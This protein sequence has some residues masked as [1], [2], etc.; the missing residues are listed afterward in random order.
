MGARKNRPDKFRGRGTGSA[1]VKA[2]TLIITRLVRLL[3]EEEQKHPC[4]SHY[5]GWP[6]MDEA[7]ALVKRGYLTASQFVL[8]CFSVTDKFRTAMW[9]WETTTDEEA[10][11]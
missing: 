3:R 5:V 9:G 2:S 7:K 1:M 11:Q 4:E 8:G 10:G 6:D